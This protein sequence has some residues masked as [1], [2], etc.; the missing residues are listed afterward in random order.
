MTGLVSGNL[1]NIVSDVYR[2]CRSLIVMVGRS[3]DVRDV[4]VTEP[5]PLFYYNATIAFSIC[6]NCFP[7]VV[8]PVE[9]KGGGYLYMLGEQ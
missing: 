8:K 1:I 4:I 6:M 9:S 5:L 2:R 7:P 3:C